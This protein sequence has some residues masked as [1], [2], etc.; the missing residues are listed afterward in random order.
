MDKTYYKIIPQFLSVSMALKYFKAQSIEFNFYVSGKIYNC[1]LE[2]IEKP[3]NCEIIP[4]HKL[5]NQFCVY[6]EFTMPGQTYIK[7]GFIE[8]FKESTQ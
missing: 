3:L 4:I 5:A 1:S 2:V 7:D 6:N 8:Y